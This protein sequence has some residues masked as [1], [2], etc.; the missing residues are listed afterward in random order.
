LPKFPSAALASIIDAT[1]I[2][3]FSRLADENLSCV[4]QKGI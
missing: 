2:A 1:G 3:S 4:K